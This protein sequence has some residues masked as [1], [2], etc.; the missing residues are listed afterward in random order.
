M[1]KG[2]VWVI[3]ADPKPRRKRAVAQP[4]RT[5][6]EGSGGAVA[7]N[8]P[9]PITPKSTARATQTE[10]PLRRIAAAYVL[11]NLAPYLQ[12][13]EDR[14]P[15]WAGI[16][17]G[18]VV[19]WAVHLTQW[20]TLRGWLGSGALPF[21]LWLGF[22][23]AVSVL[24]LVAGARALLHAGGD[25]GFF[26]SRLPVGM[27]HPKSIG[28]FGFLVPGAGLLCTGHAWKAA[29]AYLNAG[30]TALAAVTLLHWNDL[31]EIQ[32]QSA[33]TGPPSA[34]FER[35]FLV[36]VTIFMV[37]SFAWVYNAFEAARHAS[38]MQDRVNTLGPWWVLPALAVQILLLMNFDPG[39]RAGDLDRLAEQLTQAGYTYVPYQIERLALRL[40]PSNVAYLVHTSQLADELGHADEAERLRVLAERQWEK[41]TQIIDVTRS[42]ETIVAPPDAV[43]VAGHLDTPR[44]EDAQPPVPLLEAWIP[45]VT[46]RSWSN[47]GFA[48]APLGSDS[49][50]TMPSPSSP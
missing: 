7:S 3:E 22:L 49:A 21:F 19:I 28:L 2:K 18:A 45:L 42:R 34:M 4:R 30:M 37:G 39:A 47:D 46:P 31:W 24:G 10:H 32:R 50:T 33:A 26:V 27:R 6:G 9:K 20:E 43:A 44:V 35:V 36:C 16:G 13:R 40:D 14:S 11:G 41:A 48:Q 17:L 8:G 12:Q 29:F 15:V 5:A 38:R 25:T 23:L 1:S